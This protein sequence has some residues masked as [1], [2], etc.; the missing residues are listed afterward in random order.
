MS[1][2]KTPDA[3]DAICRLNGI[4][5]RTGFHLTT[6]VKPNSQA[7]AQDPMQLSKTHRLISLAILET[8]YIAFVKFS[9]SQ[10]GSPDL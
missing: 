3:H 10:A 5:I 4:V 6:F 7:N 1:G 2:E 8:T 9:I